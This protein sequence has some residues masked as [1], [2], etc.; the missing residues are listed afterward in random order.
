DVNGRSVIPK[1]IPGVGYKADLLMRVWSELSAVI[2]HGS[3]NS[4]QHTLQVFCLS[5]IIKDLNSHIF[6]AAFMNSV[7]GRKE[8]VLVPDQGVGSIMEIAATVF[9][10]AAA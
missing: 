5:G 4:L 9:R 8:I 10:P 6:P 3:F 7:L 1:A 2:F